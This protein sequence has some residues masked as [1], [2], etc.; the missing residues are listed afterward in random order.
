MLQAAETLSGGGGWYRHKA[1]TRRA[2]SIEDGRNAFPESPPGDNPPFAFGG[3]GL[4]SAPGIRR[5]A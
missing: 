2:T 1:M 4:L 3:E 5:G